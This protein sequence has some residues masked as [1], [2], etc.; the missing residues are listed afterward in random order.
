M[1]RS[2]SMRRRLS[3]GNWKMNGSLSGNGRLLQALKSGLER[4]E[5]AAF[6]VCPPF[7]HLAQTARELEGSA[8]AWGAQN[9]SEHE[10]GAYTGEV[11]G[12]MLREFGCTFVLVGHSERRAL[13]GETDEKV[14]AKLGAALRS[15]LTPVVCVG[16]SLEQRERGETEAVI[17]R[18]VDTLL[19][20]HG[21]VWLAGSVLAYEPVWAI[22]TGRT[23]TPAQ[24][25]EVHRFLRARLAARGAAAGDVPILYGGSVKASNAAELFAQPDVDGGL[26]GG[27]SLVAEEFIAI[28]RAAVPSR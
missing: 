13:Y 1:I 12:A 7:P 3:I 25:Q 19:A 14:A 16:E 20:A 2:A 22:G 21:A 27:A 6:A 9:L 11:S 8:I 15:G 18:Q 28:C 17:G 10:G 23:A 24:A 4:I 26:I 5:G